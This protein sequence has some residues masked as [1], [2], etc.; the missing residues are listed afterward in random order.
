[1][2]AGMWKKAP[3]PHLNTC[4]I[5]GRNLITGHWQSLL[6]TLDQATW[7]AGFVGGRGSLSRELII[8][9]APYITRGYVRHVIGLAALYYEDSLLFPEAINTE[10]LTIQGPVD[11]TE[12]E[13]AS[14]LDKTS[15]FL[16]NP[17]L[18]QS[19]YLVG[20][21]T[22]H[23]PA[24]QLMLVQAN[25]KEAKPRSFHITVK[26]GDTLWKIARQ[27]H[28]SVESLKG[29]NPDANKILHIGQRLKVRSSTAG[30][31]KYTTAANPLLSSRRL[32]R[33][34]VRRGDSVWGIAQRFGTSTR[35]ISKANQLGKRGLIRPGQKL[36]IPASGQYKG[37][38]PST[39]KRIRYTVRNGDSLWRIARKFGTSI[40]AIARTNKLNKNHTLRPGDRLWVL[41][42]ARSY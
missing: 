38:G 19:Q 17:G 30:K 37:K 39:N 24:D 22:F 32:V 4:S 31:L 1:M 16:L 7:N 18:E 10:A 2:G 33:Y 28:T 15:L 8:C 27:H 3:A 34:K 9:P 25:I 41:A 11:L 23:V 6:I 21:V 29:L 14:G 40:D 12:L 35:A 5:S 20:P 26:R 42:S 13:S 36:L